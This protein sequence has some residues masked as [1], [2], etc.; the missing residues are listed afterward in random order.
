MQGYAR[1]QQAEG[2]IPINSQVGHH[3][4]EASKADL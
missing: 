4:D 1:A 3:S 2:E